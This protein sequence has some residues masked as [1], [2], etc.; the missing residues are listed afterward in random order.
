VLDVNSWGRVGKSLRMDRLFCG[1]LGA[2]GLEKEAQ[3]AGR[4][5]AQY[6]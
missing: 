3:L 5:E 4:V 6:S 2:S 1:D